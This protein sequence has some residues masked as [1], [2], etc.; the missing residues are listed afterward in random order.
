MNQVI[1]NIEKSEANENLA[2]SEIIKRTTDIFKAIGHEG[3]LKILYKLTQSEK[4]V[5]MLERTLPYK[6]AAI[7]QQLARLRFSGIV[8]CRREGKMIYYNIANKKI[9]NLLTTIRDEF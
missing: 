5:S 4:T 9:S 3:R 2:E 8:N 1:L 7:S 6:Q